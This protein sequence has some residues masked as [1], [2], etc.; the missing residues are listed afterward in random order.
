MTPAPKTASEERLEQLDG[1]DTSR[2]QLKAQAKEEKKTQREELKTK[3]ISDVPERGEG[4]ETIA[5]ASDHVHGVRPDNLVSGVPFYGH[6]V[7]VTGGEDKGAFGVYEDTISLDKDG[8]PDVIR[9]RTRDADNRVILVKYAD[10][11][12]AE[13]RGNAPR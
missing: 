3:A 6:F 7:T 1:D 12:P 11:E 4:E 8:Q 10:L 5:H 9:V 2:D 13:S